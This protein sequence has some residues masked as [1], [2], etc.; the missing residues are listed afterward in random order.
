[1]NTLDLLNPPNYTMYSFYYKR[2]STSFDE[3]LNYTRV[4]TI[5]LDIQENTSLANSVYI[6]IYVDIGY[7]GI[8]TFNIRLTMFG[9]FPNHTVL[10]QHPNCSTNKLNSNQSDFTYTDSSP[11]TT[12]NKGEIHLAQVLAI[13]SEPE[14]TEENFN[15]FVSTSVLGYI[16]EYEKNDFLM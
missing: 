8:D 5:R 7:S 16:F 3:D 12:T 15:A 6:D 13:S 9:L 14:L 2:I 1:M 10:V 4:I 11:S